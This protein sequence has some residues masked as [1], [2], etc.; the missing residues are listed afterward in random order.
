MSPIAIFLIAFGII[1][2]GTLLGMY[3]RTLLSEHHLSADS[4]D[5][6]KMGTEMLAMMAA[7]VLGL[8]I[9]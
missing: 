4:R 9:S 5:V 6:M 7:L 3:L 8:L 1:F 2:G